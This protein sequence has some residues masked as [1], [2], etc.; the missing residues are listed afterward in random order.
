MKKTPVN[1]PLSAAGR[2]A[3]RRFLVFEKVTQTSLRNFGAGDPQQLAVG[4]SPPHR[5]FCALTL[6][7]T[8]AYA[9]LTPDCCAFHH[10]GID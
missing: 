1:H 4:L 9:S 6:K 8:Q 3:L 10:S 5:A 2:T 7:R